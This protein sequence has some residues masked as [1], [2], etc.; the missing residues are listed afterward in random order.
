MMPQNPELE[1]VIN[2][3]K[4]LLNNSRDRTP[5]PRFTVRDQ[6][7]LQ[8]QYLKPVAPPEDTSVNSSRSSRTKETKKIKKLRAAIALGVANQQ[9]RGS[10]FYHGRTEYH[11]RKTQSTACEQLRSLPRSQQSLRQHSVPKGFQ[12]N[13]R[14]EV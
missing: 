2:L 13:K 4:T 6:G 8:Q 11:Q 10:Q 5:Y 14:P 12:A 9:G 3:T 7:L 1:R